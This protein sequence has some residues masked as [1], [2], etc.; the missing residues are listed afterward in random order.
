M[1]PETALLP[2]STPD[3][4]LPTAVTGAFSR[5]GASRAAGRPP[6]WQESLGSWLF[7][8]L[9]PKIP[10]QATP[11]PPAALAPCEEVG[12]HRSSGP[13]T[14]AATWYPCTA[15]SPI[16]RARGAVLLLHPWSVWGQ[17]YFHRHGRLESLRAAGYHAL[18]VDLGGF[19]GSGPAS[20][21]FDRDVEDAL[22]FLRRRAHGLPVHVWGV[23]S[24]GYWAHPLLARAEGVSGA[25][26][27]DVSPHL[28]EWSWR[29]AP[30]GRPFYLFF[31]RALPAA[32]RFLDARR[33]AA[34]LKVSA[35]AYVSGER[36][37][38]IRPE[39]TEDLA[40]RAG[41]PFW[42]IPRA[43]HLGAIKTAGD[44]VIDIA[45]A[46]FEQAVERPRR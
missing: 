23:S 3:R 17:A 25:M 10:R 38:G 37:P 14:L 42:I 36:D 32:Y 11:A 22:A 8:A 2:A 29:M 33:H 30:W 19:G 16:T 20:G 26:F 43:G 6:R 28:L 31:R 7:R 13:G 4:S 9:S 27:E 34:G 40:G 41:A 21:F 15:S 24:G 12:V 18:T 39:D 45:L 44:E 5:L 1:L 46:T 35:V